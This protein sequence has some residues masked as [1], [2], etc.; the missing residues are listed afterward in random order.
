[1]P[2]AKQIHVVEQTDKKHLKGCA[3]TCGH[4]VE[5][6]LLGIKQVAAKDTR[7]EE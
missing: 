7:G 4:L 5:L 1:M 3:R 2:V 6:A